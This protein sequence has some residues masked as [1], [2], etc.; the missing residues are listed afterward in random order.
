MKLYI[1]ELNG[2]QV[3]DTVSFSFYETEYLFGEIVR[4]SEFRAP[5]EGFFDE[6]EFT[7]VGLYAGNVIEDQNGARAY[8]KGNGMDSKD[9][10]LPENSVQNAPAPE[11][12]QYTTTIRLEN[13]EAQAFMAEMAASGL[14]EEQDGGYELGLTVYDQG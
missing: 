4:L 13:A 6:G 8:S 2:W 3:G 1:A 5:V 7:I 10:I 9:V 14:M 12:S 11:L